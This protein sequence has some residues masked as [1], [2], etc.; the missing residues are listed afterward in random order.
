MARPTT[1]TC[2]HCGETKK[3]DAFPRTKR[4]RDGLSSW[5]PKCHAEATRHWRRE[6]PNWRNREETTRPTTNPPTTI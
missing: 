5:C 4:M 1:K 2:R 3:A 6:N